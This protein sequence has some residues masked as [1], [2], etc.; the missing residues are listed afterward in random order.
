M[1]VKNIVKSSRARSSFASLQ[2]DVDLTKS[3]PISGID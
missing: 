2:H 3:L 1:K